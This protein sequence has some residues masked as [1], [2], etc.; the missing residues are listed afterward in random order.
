MK[1]VEKIRTVI[2]RKKGTVVIVVLAMIAMITWGIHVGKKAEANAE[3]LALLVYGQASI[4]TW[5][6]IIPTPEIVDILR[7]GQLGIFLQVEHVLMA[8]IANA[9]SQAPGFYLSVSDPTQPK[10]KRRVLATDWLIEVAPAAADL[11]N[12]II[13][14]QSN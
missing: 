11:R 5:C 3:L 9:E 7:D 12:H 6:P 10:G 8:Q 4:P 14:L 13:D 1:L 2:K